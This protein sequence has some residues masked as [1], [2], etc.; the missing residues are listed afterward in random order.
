[1]KHK[2]VFFIGTPLFLCCN[3][4]FMLQP[5]LHRVAVRSAIT[6][7]RACCEVAADN[8]RHRSCVRVPPSTGFGLV[9]CFDTNRLRLQIHSKDNLSHGIVER[10]VHQGVQA[11]SGPAAGAKG[12]AGRGGGASGDYPVTASQSELPAI[13]M[14]ALR[15]ETKA[16]QKLPDQTFPVRRHGGAGLRIRC[17]S[18]SSPSA[19]ATGRC[20]GG[21]PLPGLAD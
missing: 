5:I 21:Y 18:A 9:P 19:K 2:I 1:M 6:I 7:E 3:Q 16:W 11:G 10:D 15:R 4:T 14:Y 13:L 8:D 20:P 12:I 17:D